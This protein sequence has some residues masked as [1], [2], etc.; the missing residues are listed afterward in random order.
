MFLYYDLRWIHDF[1]F[2]KKISNLLEIYSNNSVL[3]F[4]KENYKFGGVSYG[5][6]KGLPISFS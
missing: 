4:L 2:K 3:S 1:F 6:N 5:I